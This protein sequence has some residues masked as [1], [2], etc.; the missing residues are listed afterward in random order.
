MEYNIE[1]MSKYML[2]QRAFSTSRLGW[3]EIYYISDIHIDSHIQAAREKEIFLSSEQYII[4][5]A[6]SLVTP[7]L[8]EMCVQK[9]KGLIF[10]L[11]D[12]SQRIE[13]SELFYHSFYI[14]L[15]Y[16]HFI[17]W[18]R[19]T[20]FTGQLSLQKVQEK[21]RTLLET[22]EKKKRALLKRASRFMRYTKYHRDMSH[23]DIDLYVKKKKTFPH[24]AGYILHD[25]KKTNDEI[26]KI[27]DQIQGVIEGCDI[28]NYSKPQLKLIY[29]ILGNHE[30]HGFKKK[31]KAIETYKRKIPYVQFL[32]N[33][34]ISV[35]SK[36]GKLKC[37]IAGGTGFSKF[38]EKYNADTQINAGDINHLVECKES[39]LLVDTIEK[40]VEASSCDFYNEYTKKTEPVSCPVIVLSHMPPKDWTTSTLN[41]CVY[42]CGHD[43]KNRKVL[44]NGASIIANNQIGYTGKHIELKKEVIGLNYNPF[45]YYQ[46]GA[47]EINTRDYLLFCWFCGEGVSSAYHIERQLK[48]QNTKFYM[49]KSN[50]FYMFLLTNPKLGTR[51]C[52]GGIVKWISDISS[53]DYYETVFPIIVE[54]FLI[55]LSPYREAQEHISHRL[56]ELGFSGRIH[57]CIIDIDF[58]NHIGLDPETG[59]PT[60]Y[61]S[62]TFGLVEEYSS[63][64]ELCSQSPR[65][66][67]KNKEELAR[68][69]N[70]EGSIIPYEYSTKQEIGL[71]AVSKSLGMYGTSREMNKFQR[72]FT[73]NV[74][75]E[76]NDAYAKKL[77]RPRDAFLEMDP[78]ELIDKHW[79]NLSKVD[80]QII[81]IAMLRKCFKKTGP[82]PF[83]YKSSKM[84]YGKRYPHEEAAEDELKLFIGAIPSRFYQEPMVFKNLL[85]KTGR[86]IF[87]CSPEWL[88]TEDRLLVA[89]KRNCYSS[90]D[91]YFA[92]MSVPQ[93]VVT[94]HI[95]KIVASKFSQKNK[96]KWCK[97]DFWE[98]ILENRK[99]NNTLPKVLLAHS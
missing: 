43:H 91:Y 94:E 60:Y 38:N 96:P 18:K 53:I 6:R 32:D 69:L 79:M 68:R 33:E 80:P 93:S 9:S 64:E 72:L 63:F 8:E 51:I 11:G 40:A 89:L 66:E 26:N 35:Y 23:Y 84:I 59:V 92:M 62:P 17:N 25:L 81:D 70:K 67:C 88:W 28:R 61:Y 27:M 52:N 15:L 95:R 1:L 16:Y 54:H 82:N 87:V 65:L 13:Y 86:K 5:L 98:Y 12:I 57:G 78:Y 99:N 24:Y 75:R 20:G 58:Y 90:K 49:I 10:F 19:Y 45:I 37:I 74:L 42:F 30:L 76:W 55:A 97:R 44:D 39:E 3:L 2:P 21:Q 41:K 77:I 31:E 85:E 4:N 34:Y 7:E 56:K 46:D 50:G 73:C 29:A 48:N 83:P 71:H 14:K 47:H 36:R 22:L